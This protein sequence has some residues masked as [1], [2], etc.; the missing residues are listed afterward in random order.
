MRG[1]RE[2]SEVMVVPSLFAV[3]LYDL[4][5]RLFFVAVIFDLLGVLCVVAS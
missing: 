5:L 3:F 2:S 4:E 1:E